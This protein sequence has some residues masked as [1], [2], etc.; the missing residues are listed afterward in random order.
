MFD[1]APNSPAGTPRNVAT[2]YQ[3]DRD[4]GLVGKFH[5]DFANVLYLSGAVGNCK[6][7]DLVTDRDFRHGR[8]IWTSP[9]LYWGYP[10]Q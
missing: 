9:K 6:T 3:R 8:I 10:P 1:I 4:G 5:G 2:M 7:D